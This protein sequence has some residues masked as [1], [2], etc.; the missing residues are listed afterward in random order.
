MRQVL[1]TIGWLRV[2]GI[3]PAAAGPTGYGIVESD[4]RHCRMLHYGALK[5]AGKRQEECAAAALQDV[6][7]RVCNLIG[8]FSPDGLGVEAVSTG[9][10]WPTARKLAGVRGV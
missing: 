4:G 1:K 2:L 10:T 5:G 3:D 7:A 6:H 9:R 8:E